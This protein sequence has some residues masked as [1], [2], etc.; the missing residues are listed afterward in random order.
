MTCFFCNEADFDFGFDWSVVH[1][2]VR[3]LQEGEDDEVGTNR[4]RPGRRGLLLEVSHH[5]LPSPLRRR[6]HLTPRR[7]PCLSP[8]PRPPSPPAPGEVPQGSDLAH[9]PDLVPPV[10]TRRHQGGRRGR[11]VRQRVLDL[12]V[13]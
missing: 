11:Q 13:T 1:C 6:D 3:V 7:Q 9:R 12:S 8:P 5:R 10:L 4:Q 2:G